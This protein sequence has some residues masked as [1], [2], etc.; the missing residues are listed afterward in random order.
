MYTSPRPALRR[1]SE[2]SAP[3]LAPVFASCANT[4]AHAAEEPLLDVRL[5]TA[6]NRREVLRR[7]ISRARLTVDPRALP[8]ARPQKSRGRQTARD[9]AQ[10]DTA[11]AEESLFDLH[12]EAAARLGGVVGAQHAVPGKHTWLLVRHPPRSTGAS[13]GVRESPALCRACSSHSPPSASSFRAEFRAF[14]LSRGVR[15]RETQSRNLSSISTLTPSPR[16]S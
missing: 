1:H 9:S 14:C 5:A 2:R 16:R 13:R 15:A 10:D 3:V 7:L 4:P 11:Q 12:V 6:I 8:I